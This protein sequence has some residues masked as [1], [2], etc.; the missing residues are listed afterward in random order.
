M[1]EEPVRRSERIEDSIGS[2]LCLPLPP[3]GRYSRASYRH[4]AVTL[5][6]TLLGSVLVRRTEA[7]IIKSR[8]VETE[9]YVGPEDKGCHAY[10]GRR[11][12]RTETMFHDGGT[13][14]VYFIYG[15]Y[16]CLNVVANAIDHPEA[17]LIRAIA[18]ETDGDEARMKQFRHIR[19][20]KA[21]DLC[22]G[23]GKLCQALQID[24]Q[25]NGIDMTQSEELWVEGGT[26]PGAHRIMCAPRINIPYAQEYES[27]LWRFYVK[28]D[29]YV[30]VN[31]KQAVPFT[32]AWSALCEDDGADK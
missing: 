8:I 18:P 5:A 13:A 32:A 6:V 21:A 11:T 16:H 17:V 26:W 1:S 7:G 22:N 3:A 19:S 14:Y 31:D 2:T 28:E 12:A 24:K 4:D 10:N 15:M 20:R 27:K 23:P 25:C 30:S 29:P 9:A